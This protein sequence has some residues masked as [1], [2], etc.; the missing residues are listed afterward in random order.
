M[1]NKIWDNIPDIEIDAG[2]AGMPV[3]PI[4]QE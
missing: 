4:S 1:G 3:E 2:T